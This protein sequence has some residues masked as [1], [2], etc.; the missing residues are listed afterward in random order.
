MSGLWRGCERTSR[1][2]ELSAVKAHE[3]QLADMT[4][5]YVEVA[6]KRNTQRDELAK[7]G[8]D[9]AKM[10]KEMPVAM[11]PKIEALKHMDKE[12]EDWKVKL[13]TMQN[14]APPPPPTGMACQE[15][16]KLVNCPIYDKGEIK[17][18]LAEV[19]RGALTVLPV[20]LAP[21]GEK[22]SGRR[23]L[24]DWIASRDNPLTAR[25]IVNRVW[26]KLMGRGI[27]ETPDDF[28]RL[29]ARPT[30]PELLDDLA[31]RFMQNGWSMKWLI[32]EI[33][34]SAVYQQASGN[35]EPSLMLYA[36]RQPKRLEAEAIRDAMLALSGALDPRPLEGSQV[37]ELAKPVNPQSRELGRK[38]F[39]SSL[40]ESVPVRSIYLPVL[41]GLQTPMMQCFNAAD[42]AS[43]VGQ[44][45][46]GIV[47]AQALLLMNSD[48]VMQ[49]AE[50]FA[51]RTASIT[52][53]TQ[54]LQT[55]WRIA[56]N[57]QPTANESTAMTHALATG[58]TW[59]QLCHVLMQSA[60]F[61]TL[62]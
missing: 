60:E 56:F 44:R 28:G 40:D 33:T 3:K 45:S 21:I 36:Q 8:I 49:Q 2:L 20:A 59:P 47:P 50:A 9:P 62:Y 46:T 1:H 55:S 31:L 11:M 39:L 5:D 12:V 16:D 43:I 27:V 58:L 25:V 13:A 15:G 57:R 32:R 4:K 26:L 51:K 34:S 18:P 54:R 14:N 61:Q 24:A 29:G 35:D 38:N 17:K 22:E 37:E 41:R 52:D 48:F 19:P 30:H 23:Q 7:A 53:A 42:P 6:K 10:P